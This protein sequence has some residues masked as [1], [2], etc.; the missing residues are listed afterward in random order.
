MTA[1]W[2]WIPY[3]PVRVLHCIPTFLGGG[4]ERQLSYLCQGLVAE[5]HE[6]HV[7]LMLGGP[8]AERAREGG[9]TLHLLGMRKSYDPT[10]LWRLTTL[11]RRVRPDVVQTWLAAMDL[12]G[13]LAAQIA[14]VPWVYSE[15]TVWG[16][17]IAWRAAIRGKVIAH[18]SAVVANSEAGAAHWRSTLA[19]RVP[20]RVVPNALPVDEVRAAVPTA[21]ASL[22]L[23][24]DAE[25]ILYVGRFTPAK[26]VVLLA[27]VLQRVLERRPRAVALCCGEGPQLASF[28]ERIGAAGLASRVV[29]AGYRQ[30]VWS[31]MK[32]ADAFVST[33]DFEGR[34][35]AVV[36]AMGSGCPLALSDIPQHREVA[37]DAHAEFFRAGDPAAGAAAVER[38]L[39]LTPEERAARARRC[40]DVVSR[41][42]VEA[43]TRAYTEVYRLA[44]GPRAGAPR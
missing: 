11:I 32:C 21:R 24:D 39:S 3:P 35:N 10:T 26:N 41:F 38:V 18:A 5:G 40:D 23:A 19:P 8:H 9:A 36:E 37:G 16:N 30:D 28:R 20:I 14:G 7:A 33:S 4:A 43:M 13:G 27:S 12:W 42:S 1:A 29:T 15:R 34:P 2:R 31:V 22:G 25:V 17:D 6:V 44:V